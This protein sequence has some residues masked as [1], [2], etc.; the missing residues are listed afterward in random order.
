MHNVTRGD[1]MPLPI[2][3]VRWKCGQCKKTFWLKP[4]KAKSKRFCSRDCL[5][6]SLRVE[7]PVRPGQR[8]V[9][10]C[11]ERNC[12]TCDQ[13]FTA[14][15]HS[16]K[17]CSQKCQ[18]KAVWERN[19]DKSVKE[20][21]CEVCQ[22]VFR[23]RPKSAG[24]FCSRECNFKGQQGSL[25]PNWKGGKHVSEYGYVRISRPDHPAA[26][27]RGSYVLEHRIVMEQMIGR[28]LKEGENV[29]HINGN[30]SD[31]REEN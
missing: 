23:P 25:G 16:Q 4:V 20:R 29:H 14:R 15:T 10:T 28:F 7:N 30:R 31:N 18:I 22:T 8:H 13:L 17:Y 1:V 27:G 6:K 12:L 26:R 11:G 24:R 5:H 19:K 21:P 9:T 3:K 2:A